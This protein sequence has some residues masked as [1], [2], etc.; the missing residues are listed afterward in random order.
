MN[1]PSD[2]SIQS[3]IDWIPHDLKMIREATLSLKGAGN[4][5]PQQKMSY[6]QWHELGLTCQ[7]LFDVLEMPFWQDQL[8]FSKEETK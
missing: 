3:E 8:A 1:E 4:S 7:E 5:I 2:L 6:E